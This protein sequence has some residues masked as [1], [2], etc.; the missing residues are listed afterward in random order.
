MGKTFRENQEQSQDGH[1]R[2]SRQGDEA[3]RLRCQVSPQRFKPLYLPKAGH[4]PVT[5]P[6]HEPYV[7][8][9]YVKQVVE[10]MDE[11]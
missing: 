2:G 7:K 3:V 8:E 1:F 6:R 10:I 4:T 9:E 5:V 11:D